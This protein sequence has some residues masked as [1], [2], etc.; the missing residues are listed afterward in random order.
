MALRLPIAVGAATACRRGGRRI[1]GVGGDSAG[2]PELRLCRGA[3]CQDG[4]AGKKSSDLISPRALLPKT[5]P[6]QFQRPAQSGLA[7]N[8]IAALPSAPGERFRRRTR[9]RRRKLGFF[10]PLDMTTCETGRI[11][12]A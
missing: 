5:H 3:E 2:H 9:N 1:D 11:F 12:Y 8:A 4:H 7:A 10:L 6:A